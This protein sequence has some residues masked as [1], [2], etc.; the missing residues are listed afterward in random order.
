MK[1][2]IER[3]QFH[4]MLTQ[5]PDME[6]FSEQLK[7]GNRVELNSGQLSAAQLW[8]LRDIY[9]DA[10]LKAR[11]AQLEILH[12]ALNDACLAFQEDELEKF[13]LALTE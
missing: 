13:L 8:H 7:F 12:G 5:F 2:Q 11:A 1:L 3:A 6:S 9:A 4:A 10:G